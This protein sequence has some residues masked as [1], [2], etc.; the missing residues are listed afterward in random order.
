MTTNDQPTDFLYLVDTGYCKKEV[1]T[2]IGLSANI[3]G[4]AEEEHDEYPLCLPAGMDLF[5]IDWLNKV[6]P[7]PSVFSHHH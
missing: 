1:K 7:V 6:C 2:Q 3:F 4:L 5:V